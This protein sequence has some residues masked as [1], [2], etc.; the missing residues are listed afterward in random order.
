MNNIITYNLQ[1]KYYKY[2][3]FRSCTGHRQGVNIHYI[4]KTFHVKNWVK[5]GFDVVTWLESCSRDMH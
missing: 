5:L 3:I 1:L 4:Y 2:N